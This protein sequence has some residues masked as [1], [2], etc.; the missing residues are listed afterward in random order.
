MVRLF[1]FFTNAAFTK[2]N[3]KK[4][5]EDKVPTDTPTEFELGDTAADIQRRRGSRERG[6]KRHRNRGKRGRGRKP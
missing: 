2:K 4:S 6:R 5:E 1:L 3:G